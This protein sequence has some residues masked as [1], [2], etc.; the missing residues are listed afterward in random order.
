VVAEDSYTVLTQE[1]M[2]EVRAANEGR[3]IS[4]LL[5]GSVARSTQTSQ[6]D[7]DL[8]VIGEQLPVIQRRPNRIHVQAVTTQQFGERLRAGDDFPAWCVRY[9]VPLVM[10][11]DWL[12]IVG[13]SDANTWPDWRKKVPHAARRLTLA[14][15][16][17]DTGDVAA[18]AEEMLY[19]VSHAARAM[20]LKNGAFPLSRPEII[21]QLREAGKDRLA[22]LL[23]ELSYEEP[24]VAMLRRALR[25]IKR[26]LVHMDRPTY[27][28]F[29]ATR[30][31]HLMN[32]NGR[33]PS[34]A[35]NVQVP[36][37]RRR[38]PGRSVTPGKRKQSKPS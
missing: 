21:G 17:L 22:E 15:T 29:I 13:S 28:A 30:R 25:Y 3:Q 33:H 27:E 36:A 2:R 1:F 12:R 7:L 4:I 34:E 18:A 31:Q 6:S 19:A 10:S 8:L 16:L 9:G 32:K 37:R 23:Q 14:A 24:T 5:I 26:L 20:L 38:S 11:N 35:N